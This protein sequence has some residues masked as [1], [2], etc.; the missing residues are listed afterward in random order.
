MRDCVETRLAASWTGSYAL[1]VHNS[2]RTSGLCH[3]R[4][5]SRTYH[6]SMT[7]NARPTPGL[8]STQVQRKVSLASSSDYNDFNF[9]HELRRLV[10][11]H[12]RRCRCVEI[13]VAGNEWEVW[14]FQT[15]AH[16]CRR[17][18]LKSACRSALQSSHFN[19]PSLLRRAGRCP[20]RC[21][22]G[23]Q[24]RFGS[25]FQQREVASLSMEGQSRKQA[26]RLPQY[27]KCE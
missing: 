19:M 6:I 26:D 3:T 1:R 5:Y 15:R 16:S 8:I 14:H 21:V 12:R 22:G 2:S 11:G 17:S 20:R 23:A 10:V 13:D 7:A 18:A 27:Q 9:A 24:P 25:N 4:P